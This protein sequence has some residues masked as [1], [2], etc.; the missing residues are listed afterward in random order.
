MSLQQSGPQLDR[1]SIIHETS[2]ILSE[3]VVSLYF[4]SEEL[5]V[6]H[7]QGDLSCPAEKLYILFI[8]LF[9][10]SFSFKESAVNLFKFSVINYH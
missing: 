9:I 3:K 4:R 6:F 8:N 1:I 5:I 10:F 7:C 2:E